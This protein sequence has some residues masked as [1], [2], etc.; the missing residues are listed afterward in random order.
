MRKI[1]VIDDEARIVDI[2]AEYLTIKGFEVL[3]AYGGQEGL[4]I[5]DNTPSIDLIILDKKM[6]QIGGAAIIRHLRNHGIDIPVVVITG[7]I[8]LS[9]L[10]RARDMSYEEVLFK[11]VRLKVLLDT[12]KRILVSRS[13]KK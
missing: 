13:K 12:V 6:P 2:I 5:I 10:I 1:L 11:P 8:T 7:S 4:D 3:R 9:Q